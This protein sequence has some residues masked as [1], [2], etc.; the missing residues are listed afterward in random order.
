ML[1][2]CPAC[3]TQFR[4][5]PDQ[6]KLRGGRVR[7]GECQHVFNALDTLIEEPAVV[8]A[9]APSAAVEASL[10]SSVRLH[11]L[12]QHHGFP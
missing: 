6:L 8:I 1:T 3:A 12:R 5:T 11:R 2:R 9:P 7:C 4:V 10:Q